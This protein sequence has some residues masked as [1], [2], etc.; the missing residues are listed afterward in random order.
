M[1]VQITLSNIDWKMLSG[2]KLIILELISRKNDLTQAE[3]D[4]LNGMIHLLDEIQDQAAEQLGSEN[5]FLSPEGQ[6]AEKAKL[7]AVVDAEQL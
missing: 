7:I 3:D 1:S 5:V 4:V 6:E 2:Q